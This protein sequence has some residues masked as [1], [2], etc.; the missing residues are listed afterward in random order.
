MFE[1][2]SIK[3]KAD[4][5]V[6]MKLGYYI[7]IIIKSLD[8]QLKIKIYEYLIEK[9]RGLFNKFDGEVNA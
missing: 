9:N 3:N 5:I 2:V 6:S 4:E 8:K 1:T 7:L